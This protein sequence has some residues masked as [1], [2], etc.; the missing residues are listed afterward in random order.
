VQSLAG[1][2]IEGEVSQTARDIFSEHRIPG[3]LQRGVLDELVETDDLTMYGLM[4]AI[5]AAANGDISP[6]HQQLLMSTGGD[7][8]RH[9][10]RCVNCRRILPEGMQHVHD[11]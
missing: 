3:P 11:E 1:E 2:P 10:E 5:T 9:A 7:V 8:S 4:N 6:Q